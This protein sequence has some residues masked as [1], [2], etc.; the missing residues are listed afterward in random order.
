MPV[1]LFLLPCAQD[2]PAGPA[3]WTSHECEFSYEHSP[4][5][6]LLLLQKRSRKVRGF[7][8]HWGFVSGGRNAAEDELSHL[9][10]ACRR[11]A[12]RLAAVREAAEECGGAACWKCTKGE[13][14]TCCRLCNLLQVDQK[15]KS[16]YVPAS[17]PPGV[18]NHVDPTRGLQHL[19]DGHFIYV[20][21]GFGTDAALFEQ[22]GWLKWQPR[23]KY[24]WRGE[25]NEGEPRT[26][27]GY[28]WVPIGAFKRKAHPV[29][30]HCFPVPGSTAAAAWWLF[31]FVDQAKTMSLALALH[32]ANRARA[33]TLPRQLPTI[34]GAEQSSP[35][36]FWPTP[37]SSEDVSEEER[38]IDPADGGAYT[39]RQFVECC[40][41]SYGP[42]KIWQYWKR[43][44][45]PSTSNTSKPES[46][47][48]RDQVIGDLPR[49][50]LVP[51]MPSMTRLRLLPTLRSDTLELATSTT[52][53]TDETT[54]VHWGTICKAL[55][56]Q[57]QRSHE[58]PWFGLLKFVLARRLLGEQ[59]ENFEFIE[60]ETG[61]QLILEAHR[62]DEHDRPACP[63]HIRVVGASKDANLEQAEAMVSQLA[64]SAH[65]DHHRLRL[66]KEAS[67]A[68]KCVRCSRCR[69]PDF[70]H[71]CRACSRGNGRSHSPQCRDRH[72][73]AGFKSLSGPC[74][75]ECRKTHWNS[76]DPA[77]LA[78][79]VD[80]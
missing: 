78:E 40:R 44:R 65:E 52:D 27:N 54:V 9:S 22:N 29:S 6:W 36:A 80:A 75:S 3:S 56:M 32:R 10:P 1:I 41:R 2:A 38:R 73:A 48:S 17:L 67:A 59:R 7:P 69:H 49:P 21:D 63:T 12:E 79:G 64:Q 20:L 16:S 72:K 34:S 61:T 15:G 23:A 11:Q 24:H 28:L 50:W 45:K 74:V 77:R 46:A 30:E 60:S 53:P 58:M 71:C 37:A 19:S 13:P 26:R 43:S 66:C 76:L 33:T 39:Y 5:S 70:V 62:Q 42:A 31:D 47:V 18:A 8:G 35:S 55:V 4:K 68:G 57:R 25:V 14:A 51:L